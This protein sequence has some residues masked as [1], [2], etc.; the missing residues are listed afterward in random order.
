M[1]TYGRTMASR[2][3]GGGTS[4]SERA[5]SSSCWSLFVSLFQI[6]RQHIFDPFH[7]CADPARQSAP[8]CYG[9][10]HGARAATCDMLPSINWTVCLPAERGIVFWVSACV[11]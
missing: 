3:P 10:E 5:P 1:T 4:A 2:R 8:M 7:E 9:E 6:R 11:R